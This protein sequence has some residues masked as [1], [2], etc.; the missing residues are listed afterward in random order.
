[1][2]ATGPT[3]H[4]LS[5]ARGALHA[6]VTAPPRLFVIETPAATAI[7]LGC[8]YDL[9][10]AADGGAV[11]TVT[12]GQVELAGGGRLSLVPMGAT[13]RTR[14]G[15]GPGLPWSTAWASPELIAAIDRF[16][17]RFDAGD[18]AAVAEILAHAE[19]RDTVTLYNL[20]F[21]VETGADRLRIYETIAALAGVPETV[22][23]EQIEAGEYEA[24]EQL[25]DHLWGYWLAPEQLPERATGWE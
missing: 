24:A 8:A 22:L 17:R 10:V 7:D 3:E 13:A 12:K 11:L 20:L 16:D 18:A 21:R 23:P 25:R 4:R 1:L 14:A 15:A 6:E 19:P 9:E 2:V 5:L